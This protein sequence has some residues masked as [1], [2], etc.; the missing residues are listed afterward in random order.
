MA[1][2]RATFTLVIV[3]PNVEK[4]S[5]PM[6]ALKSVFMFARLRIFRHRG[7]GF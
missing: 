2:H 3:T 1:L 4:L 7:V 5:K 6:Y